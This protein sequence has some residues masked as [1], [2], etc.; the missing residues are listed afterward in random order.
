[1][2]KKDE[3]EDVLVLKDHQPDPSKINYPVGFLRIVK[4]VIKPG[5]TLHPSFT[6]KDGEIVLASIRTSYDVNLKRRIEVVSKVMG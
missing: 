6:E 2:K 1:M 3:F 5:V 4:G